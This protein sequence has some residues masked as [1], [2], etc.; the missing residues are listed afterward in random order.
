VSAR[1]AFALLLVGC[2]RSTTKLES[3]GLF[4]A[5]FDAARGHRRILALVSPT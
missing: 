1:V 2:A 3:L 4:G 5:T